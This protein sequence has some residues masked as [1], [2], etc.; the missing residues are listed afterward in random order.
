MR[1]LYILGGVLSAGNGAVFALL[2]ELQDDHGLPTWSLGTIAA[3]AFAAGLASQLSLARY[4]DRGQARRMLAVG[5]T[6]ACIGFVATGFGSE[7]WQLIGA[8]AMAGLGIGMVFPAA[9]KVL[10]TLHPDVVGQTLGRFLAFDVGGFVLGAPIAAAIAE[11][12]GVKLAFGSL[13]AAGAVC[14]PIV[15][16]RPLPPMPATET[17]AADR[18]VLRR[19]LGR[20]PLRAGLSLGV[21][22]FGA[23]G[24]FDTIWAR[25]LKDL[26]ASPV[27]IGVTLACFGLPMAALAGR[28]GRLADQR[29]PLRVGL[30]GV[31]ASVPMMSLYGQLSALGAAHRPRRGPFDRGRRQHAGDPG[32]GGVAVRAARDRCRPGAALRDADDHGGA[33]RPGRRSAVRALRGRP[34]VPRHRGGHGPGVV[35]GAVARGRA[36]RGARD[37]APGAHRRRR[38]DLE[39][40]PIARLPPAD[41]YG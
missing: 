26:G 3:S 10:V 20:R 2:P 17:A 14:L 8:W 35:V 30:V 36:G 15:L 41:Q 18:R 7:L 23:I 12:G 24:V 33:R 1:L 11:V 22:T 40:S 34:H 28:G 6:L 21:A 32:G 4:A 29:G 38:G 31:A 5:G 27:F 39:L 13:A 37:A 25:Y 9:R 16:R 19:L